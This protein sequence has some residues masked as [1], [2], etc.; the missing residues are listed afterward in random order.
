MST[1]RL[2]S[3][4]E[5]RDAVLAA[6]PGPLGSETVAVGGSL[7]R[8]LAEPAAA[9][10]LAVIPEEHATLAAGSEVELWWLDR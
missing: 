4:E 9:E 6:I 2:L 5:A 1:S 3:L 8:V 7:W 10:A